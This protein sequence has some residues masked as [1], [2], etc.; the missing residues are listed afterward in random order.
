MGV[1]AIEAAYARPVN[2]SIVPQMAGVCGQTNH[3]KLA[4]LLGASYEQK[5]S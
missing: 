2:I 4:E 1:G 3:F 5:F